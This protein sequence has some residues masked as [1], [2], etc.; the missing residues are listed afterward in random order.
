MKIWK[1]MTPLIL[2]LQKDLKPLLGTGLL[3]DESHIQ[4]PSMFLPGGYTGNYDELKD[5][6]ESLQGI[7]K[8]CSEKD[9]DSYDANP[10]SPEVIMYAQYLIWLG[11]DSG[12]VRMFPHSVCPMPDGDIQI[13]WGLQKEFVGRKI[14]IEVSVKDGKPSMWWV[15][16]DHYA[17]QKCWNSEKTCREEGDIEITPQNVEKIKKILRKSSIAL[18]Y[19]D[20]LKL[21]DRIFK[22]E[23]EIQELKGSKT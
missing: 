7:K 18:W 22:L 17:F 3:E 5:C 23:K 14:D 8:D 19:D 13:E 11:F 9:W 20:Q 16:W 1:E 6:L 15:D 10:I 4:N 12:D 2:Q 21:E